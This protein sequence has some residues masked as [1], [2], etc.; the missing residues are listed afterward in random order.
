MGKKIRL[1]KF[2]VDKGFFS[3]RERSQDAIKNGFVHVNGLPAN[4]PASFVDDQ[5]LIEIKKHAEHVSRGALKLIKALDDFS[6]EPKD[7]NVID[8]GAST[9]GFTEVLLSRGAK[10]VAA[11]DVGYGQLDWKLRT[12][13][14]VDVFERTNIRYFT[15]AE[16]GY[17]VDL[18]VIDVSFISL[19]KVIVPVKE[20]F[21]NSIEIVALVKPQFEAPKGSAKNG[22]VRD[23]D[24]HEQ[25]LINFAD[26]IKKENLSIVNATY[27]P[28]TGA[29][30]NIE[31]LVHILDANKS[32]NDVKSLIKKVVEHAHSELSE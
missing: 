9:G 4:K 24:V 19:A 31:F 10:K 29:K 23:A 5:S 22:I 18:A 21:Q 12:D 14:R 16:L 11:V 1:D 25:V 3:T 7:K 2:L 26:E 15:K 6:V 17:G 20:L 28:V 32:P 27:S 8:V 30:G 13:P